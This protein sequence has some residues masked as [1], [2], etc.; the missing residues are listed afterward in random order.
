MF[1]RLTHFSLAPEKAAE[2]KNVYH[3]EVAPVIHQ[4]PGIIDVMLLEPAEGD[5]FISCTIWNSEADIKAFESSPS[6]P[7]VFGRIR[8]AAAK[9]PM[10]KYY[11]VK[12]P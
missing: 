12:K 11:N 5:E 9:P 6:Y 1:V 3:E 10:Q 4:Q 7:D 8:A 2:I